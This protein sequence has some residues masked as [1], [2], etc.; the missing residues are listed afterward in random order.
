MRLV[1]FLKDI[2]YTS[3]RIEIRNSNISDELAA[4]ITIQTLMRPD[5]IEYFNLLKSHIITP[6][7]GVKAII[8][9]IVMYA[10]LVNSKPKAN[11]ISTLLQAKKIVEILGKSDLTEN[12]IF[13]SSG[14]SRN[15]KSIFK[16]IDQIINKS[17]NSGLFCS[18]L[19]ERPT[20]NLILKLCSESFTDAT[21]FIILSDCMTGL[22][23][24]NNN[25]GRIEYC[26]PIFNTK[27]KSIS[28]IYIRS[29]H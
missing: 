29:I 2:R 3:E 4:R 6:I 17:T 19:M 22:S 26:S 21:C 7:T 8:Y 13:I 12:K 25:N 1:D 18:L 16:K 28:C 11:H 27:K 23:M 10:F 14:V 15:F 24:N 5:I 9:Y 20:E